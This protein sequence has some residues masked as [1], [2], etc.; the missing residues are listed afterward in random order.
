MAPFLK[1]AGSKRHLV[2]EL[3]KRMPTRFGRYFEPFCGS[4][5]L[6]FGLRPERAVLGDING[7]LINVYQAVVDH[8]DDVIRQLDRHRRL[9]SSA[10]FYRM[11]DQWNAQRSSWGSARRASAFIYFNKTA[12][13]GLWRVNSRGAM[14]VP[15]GRY[16]NPKICDRERLR[17]AGELL[18]HAQLRV[19]D[20]RTTLHDVERGDL[21]YIDSPHQA[22]SKTANFTSYTA[23]AFT[24]DDQAELAEVAGRLVRKGCHVILSNADTPFVRR[25]YQGFEIQRVQVPRLINSAADRRGAVDEVIICSRAGRPPR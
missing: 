16:T 4:A 15:L 18:R 20:Y 6:Y 25:L 13:N 5:A 8:F 10:Y 12:F 2:P 24:E 9:H 21:I 23:N 1:Y 11:R 22:R 3:L 14:N 7:D 17:T 19:G